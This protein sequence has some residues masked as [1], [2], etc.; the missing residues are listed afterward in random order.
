MNW[1]TPF[2]TVANLTR[3]LDDRATFP[4]GVSDD[5]LIELAEAAERLATR[6]RKE[7]LNRWVE[8]QHVYSPPYRMAEGHGHD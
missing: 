8:A 1:A 6:A 3:L 5:E 4:S 2:M 7:L